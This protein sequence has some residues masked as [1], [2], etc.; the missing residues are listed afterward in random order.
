LD[1][2]AGAGSSSQIGRPALSVTMMFVIA[3]GSVPVL[4]CGSAG[5]TSSVVPPENFP[6]TGK[7]FRRR[8]LLGWPIVWF[9][10]GPSAA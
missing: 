8:L 5:K 4:R 1:A 9:I 3:A 6:G 10:A 2:G 7:M